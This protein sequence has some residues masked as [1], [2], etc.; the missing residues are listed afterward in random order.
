MN[1]SEVAKR[2]VEVL[3]GAKMLPTGLRE[4]LLPSVSCGID[5]FPVIRDA[6][7]T[8]RERLTVAERRQAKRVVSWIDAQRRHSARLTFG[9][10]GGRTAM[11]RAWLG[12]RLAFWPQGV[13]T[14][15]RV[16]L[17]SSR[18]GRA[19]DEKPEWFRAVRAACGRLQAERDV[20]VTAVGTTTCP[21]LERCAV[22]F[23]LRL[24]RVR[25]AERGDVSQWVRQ[26]LR[27]KFQP[28]RR[29]VYELLLSPPLF[30]HASEKR[31]P[32]D[33]DSTPPRDRAVVAMSDELM[34]IHLRRG[35]NLE[36][37]LRARLADPSQREISVLLAVGPNLVPDEVV[38][39][40]EG[41][42][43][44]RWEPPEQM[45]HDPRK[46][47][48]LSTSVSPSVPVAATA[49]TARSKAS[50]V[51]I[52]PAADWDFLTHC[53]RRHDGPWPDQTEEE[54]WD[55]LLFGLPSADR[56]AL[57]VL[58][59]IVQQRRL[60]GSAAA[61][62]GGYR[63]VSFTAVPLRQVSR[64]RTFRAHRGRWDFEPYGLCIRCEWLQQQGA[65][66]VI[67]GDDESWERLSEAERPFF[68]QRLSTSAASGRT[69]DWSVE[70]EWRVLGDLDL[71]SLG[72]EEA[73]LFVAT[74][75]EA[76]QL[77]AVS[78]W[79]IAIMNRS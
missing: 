21:V 38:E 27:T 79:P 8:G 22:H 31:L 35:G 10:V 70:R 56:S 54:Y 77:A 39:E 42:G 16:G 44:V 53:T 58:M 78:P 76:H 51:P 63:V 32:G 37:L 7:A 19:L 11:V 29:D 25:I 36:R 13:P 41:A 15:R 30:P 47:A 20:L 6:W 69:I 46:T 34:A 45:G 2:L 4:E 62:R 28:P 59:R 9:L 66:P 73:F 71:G 40:L 17:I 5:L 65:R 14:G 55:E 75:S 60:C 52:P 33:T 50:L 48:S 68:Q 26:L 23:G 64:L 24:L 74:E 12:P 18:L 43:A 72:P 1:D 49:A 3:V 61:I 57:A 67:Y